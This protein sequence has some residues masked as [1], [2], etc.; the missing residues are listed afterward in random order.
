MASVLLNLTPN[1]TRVSPSISLCSIAIAARLIVRR[2]TGAKN[3][4]G[5]KNILEAKAQKLIT[6]IPRSSA[7]IEA[8]G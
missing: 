7:G 3:G 6:M 4:F 8:E 2:S 5:Q 1:R